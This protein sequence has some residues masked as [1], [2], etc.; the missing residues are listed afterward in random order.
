L[1]CVFLREVSQTT[2]SGWP[3]T[4]IL[5]ISSSRVARIVGMSHQHSVTWEVMLF[6]CH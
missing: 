4:I 6:L 3:W 1:C 2:C 5:L